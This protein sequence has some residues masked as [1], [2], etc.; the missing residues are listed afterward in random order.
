MSAT[1][2]FESCNLQPANTTATDGPRF[3]GAF[4]F[5]ADSAKL[6]LLREAAKQKGASRPLLLC[7]TPPLKGSPKAIPPS[8][9]DKTKCSR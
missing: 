6:A 8:P 5:G 9:Q 2:R 1:N 4:C 3:A 7:L